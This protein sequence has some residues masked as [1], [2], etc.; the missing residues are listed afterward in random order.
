MRSQHLVVT[1]Y[2]VKGRAYSEFSPEWLEERF[3]VVHTYCLPS[4]AQQTATDFSSL[5]LCD[6]TTDQ[7]YVAEIDERRAPLVSVE[8]LGE[9]ES[10]G[11]ATVDAL[12]SRL[13]EP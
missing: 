6:E 7:D 10:V 9:I 11:P 13:R 3:R 5:T 8:E 4:M 1:R 2:T 12:R